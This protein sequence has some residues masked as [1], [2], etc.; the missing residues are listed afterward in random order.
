MKYYSTLTVVLV[1]TLVLSACGARSGLPEPTA[2]PIDIQ[3]TMAAA[4]FTVVAQTQAALPTPTPTPAPTDTPIP[5]VTVPPLPTLDGTATP[6]PDAGSGGDDSCI[7]QPLP[8][9]L[10]GETVRMRIT[11][12]T[13]AD[14]SVTVYLNQ[15]G[16]QDPCGYRSY[17]LAAGQFIVLNDLVEGCYTLWAWNPIPDEYFIVT[18]GTSCIDDSDNW[19]FD[20]S[21]R[22]ITLRN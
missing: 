20:I 17:T 21:T 11:N 2:D 10:Q 15:F 3:G 6:A 9:A 13:R 14:L 22:S 1:I 16:P 12:S 5:T 8:A 7:Y 4:A 18:N 19:V